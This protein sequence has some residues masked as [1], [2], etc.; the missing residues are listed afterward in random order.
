MKK[1]LIFI[2]LVFLALVLTTG[3]FAYT[4]TNQSAVTLQATMADG[5]WA[6]Y[7]ESAN[8]PDWN[9]VLPNA[10]TMIETLI[11]VAD[12]CIEFPIQYPCSGQHFEKVTD[13]ASL[14]LDAFISTL[15]CLCTKTDLFYL[16]PFD[17]MGG[18]AKIT[19]VTIYFRIAACGDYDVTARGALM[20]GSQVYEG[21]Y[22]TVHGANFMTKSWTC[23]VNPDTGKAWTWAEVNNLQAGISGCGS[24]LL[25]PL[26]CTSVYVQVNYTYTLIQGAVPAGDL[27]NIDPYPDYTGDLSIK[28]YLTN[29]A[30]LLKAYEYLNMKL[31]MAYSIEAGKTPEYQV[32]SIENG[33]VTFNIQGGSAGR[34]TVNIVGG[35]YR[36]VSDNPQEWGP[37]WSVIPEF[38]CEVTQR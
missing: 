27:Y 1:K 31:Y 12:G 13:Y 4:Y 22:V 23:S 11:P 37:G 18:T 25:R 3:T 20:T 33:V 8:Q 19:G 14:D 2:G 29:T 5:A 26:F 15:G 30:A 36:L 34:Y 17:G 28:I 38:Y 32:L 16:S 35:G 24:G 6:T 9:R 10:N 7:Q 21:P